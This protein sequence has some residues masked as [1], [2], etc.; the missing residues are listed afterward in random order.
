[1]EKY[2]GQ[3]VSFSGEK[4]E[5]VGYSHNKS[6][7]EPLPITDAPQVGGR[8]RSAPGPFDAVFKEC[9]KYRYIGINGLTD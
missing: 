9:E 1:M 6:A 5:V 2:M 4:A 3:S 8:N 7:D